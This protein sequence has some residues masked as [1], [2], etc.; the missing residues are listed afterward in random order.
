VTAPDDGLFP[1]ADA[2]AG[3]P[4]NPAL[5]TPTPA[6]IVATLTRPQREQRVHALIAQAHRIHAD[7]IAAHRGDRTITATC[8]LWSGGHDSTLLAHLM[9]THVT[10]AVHANTGIGIEQTRQFVR[11]TAAA[12]NLPLL[13][14]HPP[15]G[16]TYREFVLRHG[17]PGPAQHHRMFQ[18]I[19]ERALRQVRRELVTNGRR[20][21]VVFVAGR[22]RAESARRAGNLRRG[23]TPIPLHEREDSVIWTSPIANWTTLDMNT[24]RLMHPDLPRNPVADVLHMSGE[25]LCGSY[26][27]DGERQQLRDWY[28]EVDAEITSLEQAAR[29]AGVPDPLAT[30]GWAAPHVTAVLEGREVVP[31]IRAL[32][33]P[34]TAAAGA[35]CSSCPDLFSDYAERAA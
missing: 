9:R 1:V 30:W 28:P 14:R 23:R 4:L 7:G 33:K 2:W 17:F 11:D 26:A 19:K 15:A 35:L 5:D 29:A 20:Q 25:C 13:E 34:P 8:L 18:R 10:H 24:Y 32:L 31:A 16:S 22:R 12:W 3:D 21:R 27:K 6:A